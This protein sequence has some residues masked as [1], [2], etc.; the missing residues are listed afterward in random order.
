MDKVEKKRQWV[1]VNAVARDTPFGQFC[2]TDIVSFI[3]THHKKNIQLNITSSLD[4]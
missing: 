3:S 4:I 1:C 2:A